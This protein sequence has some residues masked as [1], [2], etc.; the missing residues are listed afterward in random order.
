MDRRL[1]EALY[2]AR[3]LALRVAAPA[4]TVY[5][6]RYRGLPVIR[7]APMPEAQ[8]RPLEGYPSRLWYPEGAT[9]TFHLRSPYA[10][11]C[12][13]VQQV[14]GPG[15]FERVA[16][17]SFG[18]T[19]QPLPPDAPAHGCGWTPTLHLSLDER[20]RPGYYR[21]VIEAEGASA[22]EIE[23][24]AVTFLV[25]RERPK[26]HVA[27]LAPVATWLAY[28]PWG[29]QSLYHNERSSETTYFASAARPNPAL[30]WYSVENIHAMRAEANAFTWL[31]T[32][33]GA[34]LYPD[35]ALEEPG[36]LAPYRVL[37]LSYHCEYVS[38]AMYQGLRGLVDG[39]RSLL[40]LGANHVFWRILWRPEHIGIECRKDGT[41]FETGPGRGGL[42]RH[43]AHPEDRLLGVRFT[44][45]AG[46]GTYAPYRVTDASHWLYE[47][48]DVTSGEVFGRTGI[49][50]LPI[51]GDETDEPTALSGLAAEV[52]ASGLNRAGAVDGAYTVW[53]EEDPAWDG[54]A[55]GTIALTP[56]SDHHAVLSTGAIH[57]AS[58]LGADRVFT[59]L[60]RNFLRRYGAYP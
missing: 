48:L 28:N 54:A 37:V 21:A 49:T 36:L 44:A 52:V 6:L 42:W 27:V 38:D 53:R 35:W 34:D 14:A 10:E 51:C 7:Y 22:G 20:F 40:A 12:L 39:G 41:P 5:R 50:P 11:N 19:E 13:V 16:A 29:G 26:N 25:G 24:S 18:H 4:L 57:S 8:P 30:G 46:I 1:V 15:R 59:G 45:P 47:G 43:T 17:P 58:G 60:V 56:R 23:G 55:G 31:D 32:E 3:G 9:A 33:C 2:S